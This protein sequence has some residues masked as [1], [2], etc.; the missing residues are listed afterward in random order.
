MSPVVKAILMQRT[1]RAHWP[2]MIFTAFE[3]LLEY[4]CGS[5]MFRATGC[6][7]SSILEFSLAP[8]R[9]LITWNIGCG[10]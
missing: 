3:S 10:L 1:Q 9:I 8:C 5:I 4:I 6:D 2:N 7:N